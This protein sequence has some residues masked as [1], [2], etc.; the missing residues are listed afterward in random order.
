MA[1][2][3]LPCSF[4][5]DIPRPYSIIF[6][7][8]PSLFEKEARKERG[9][10]ERKGTNVNMEVHS[11][12]VE[13]DHSEKMREVVGVGVCVGVGGGRTGIERDE[14]R[15]S[16]PE[17]RSHARRCV[18]VRVRAHGAP[19]R[20]KR[21]SVLI[22][23]VERFHLSHVEDDA[24]AHGALRPLRRQLVE[25]ALHLADGTQGLKAVVQRARRRIARELRAF[26]PRRSDK[27]LPHMP[28]KAD[29]QIV[30]RTQP[31]DATGD[32]EPS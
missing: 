23:S 26:T 22:A 27:R 28:R 30:F 18:R 13:K 12:V 20:I 11:Y 15:Q 10:E 3:P 19:A 9:E 16:S 21:A 25:C 14:A 2:S 29:D 1:S 8:N 31:S 24:R 32:S 4:A 5:G 7:L 17:G 6:A